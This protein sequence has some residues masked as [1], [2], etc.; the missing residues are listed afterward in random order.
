VATGEIVICLDDDIAGL[1]NNAMEALDKVFMDPTV[2]AVNF[3]VL[4]KDT[5]ELVNWVHHCASE[6]YSD[7]IFNTYEI[8][9][10]AV[11]FRRSPLVA[12][13]GYPESFFLSHEGPDLAYRLMNQGLRVIY[14]PHISVAHSFACEGRTSWRNYY[15]DTRNT[16]WLAARNLPTV[17]GGRMVL[18]QSLAML[19]YALRDG[20]TRWWLKGMV[21]GL[22][23]LPRALRERRCLSSDA[24]SRVMSID[25]LRPSLLYILRKRL[26]SRGVTF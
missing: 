16:F 5:G 15:F 4:A 23:G 26:F 3:K 24:F 10:G 1:C 7:I 9:E 6:L 21:D 25:R 19:V 2:A 11:A 14:C 12:V 20:Y 18:R 17:Y 8:T 13:G 22:T